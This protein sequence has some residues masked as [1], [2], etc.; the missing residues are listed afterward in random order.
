MQNLLANSHSLIKQNISL[1]LLLGTS[2]V[3]QTI[4]TSAYNAGEWG[5][6]PVSGRSPGEGNGEPLQCSC[7]ENPMDRRANT[8]VHLCSLVPWGNLYIFHQWNSRMVMWSIGGKQVMWCFDISHT[9]ICLSVCL[10]IYLS[11]HHHNASTEVECVS[12]TG[13]S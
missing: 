8:A 4:K 5:V 10:S 9:A 12:K 7:L 1:Y 3:A 13:K 2:L 11:H 6:I